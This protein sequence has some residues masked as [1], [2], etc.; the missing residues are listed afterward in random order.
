MKGVH[1]DY[2][3]DPSR[4]TTTASTFQPSSSPAPGQSPLRVKSD[5]GGVE[6]E[7]GTFDTCGKKLAV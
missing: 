3:Y 6:T 7:L 4:E 5:S 1:P 2:D